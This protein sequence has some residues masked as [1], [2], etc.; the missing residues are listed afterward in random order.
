MQFE[1][2]TPDERNQFK[3]EAERI[4]TAVLGAPSSCQGKETRWGNK[5]SLKLLPSGRLHDFSQ[6]ETY[7]MVEVVMLHLGMAFKDAVR[8]I[9]G[10]LGDIELASVDFK[11]RRMPE[12][13]VW[14]ARAEYLWNGGSTMPHGGTHGD[15]VDYLLYDRDLP[16]I[17]DFITVKWSRKRKLF[18]FQMVLPDGTPSTIKFL[19]VDTAEKR[20]LRGG[21]KKGTACLLLQRRA[22]AGERTAVVSEGFENALAFLQLQLDQRNDLKAYDLWCCGDKANLSAWDHQGSKVPHYSR[23][24]IGSDPEPGGIQAATQLKE[25]MEAKGRTVELH[26]PEGGDWNDVIAMKGGDR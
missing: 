16:S 19:N 14:P 12:P 17:P 1:K 18:M 8:W 26:I 7:D 10:L 20:Y 9:R 22:T 13:V 23:V 6:D 25:R 21:R 3:A 15:L 2:L 24:I 5:G 4:C 11:P